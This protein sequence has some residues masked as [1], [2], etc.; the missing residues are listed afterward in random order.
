MNI[1]MLAFNLM[2]FPGQALIKHPDVQH[3]KASVQN[4]LTPRYKVFARP[5][6]IATEIRKPILNLAIAMQQLAWIKGWGARRKYSTYPLNS[7]RFI[8]LDYFSIGNFG[9]TPDL[10]VLS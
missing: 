2:S 4:T 1:A 5:A 9:W 3:G 10:R 8:R 7:S 6:F